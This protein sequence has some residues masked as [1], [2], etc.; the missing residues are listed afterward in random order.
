MIIKKYIQFNENNNDIDI[1]D[2]ISYLVEDC[3]QYF[4]DTYSLDILVN[5]S[6]FANKIPISRD[7][8]QKVIKLSQKQVKII[9]GYTISLFPQ[10]I[11]NENGGNL[12]F[13]IYDM[14]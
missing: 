4:C 3:F 2:N 10:S 13:H 11:R 6:V 14:T 7:M 12:S 5:K 1:E 9:D 8:I